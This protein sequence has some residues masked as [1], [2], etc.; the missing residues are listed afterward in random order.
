MAKI[1]RFVIA[2]L[3]P[4][5]VAALI[6]YGRQVWSCVSLHPTYFP[7]PSPPIATATA[8]L[9]ALQAAEALVPHGGSSAVEERDLKQG[10]VESDLKAFKAYLLALCLANPAMADAFI[11]AAG[12]Q[13]G[14]RTPFAKPFL[15]ARMGKIPNQVILRAKAVANR[16]VSYCWQYSTDG[17]KTWLTIGTTTVAHTSLLNTTPLTTY[18]FRFQSTVKQVTSAWSQTITFT[19]PA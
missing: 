4:G 10:V 18:L 6:L 15:A 14:K 17:G 7:T 19:T 5:N 12:L 1:K 2:L 3:L 9:D 13:Q 16:S 8:N 11:A